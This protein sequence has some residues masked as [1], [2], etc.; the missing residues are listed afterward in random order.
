MATST[1]ILGIDGRPLV[2]ADG[3]A[4]KPRALTAE[5]EL[6]TISGVRQLFGETVAAGLL[7]GRLAA[8]LRRAQEGDMR[9]FLTLAEEMEERELQYASV[10]STRKRAIAGIE[11]VL[12][13]RQAKQKADEI[14][15]AIREDILDRP[16]FGELI[17]DLLDG[18]GKGY[19]AVEIIWETGARRW[20]PARFKRHDPRVF[21][22]DRETLSELRLRAD[23]NADG[24]PLDPLKWIIHCPRLKSG[25]PARSGLARLAAWA[26]MMKSFT[27][28]DWMTFLEVYGMPLRLG[29]YGPGASAEDK[30]VLLRAVRD[31]GSDAAAI[32]P[33][34]MEI[35]FVESKGFS[36]KPFEAMADYLDKQ[37]SKA[38]I[39]QTMTADAGSSKAQAEVHDL[40]R[41]DI[42]KADADQLAATLNRML[43]E[44]YVAV[45]FGPGAHGAWR[46]ALPVRVARDITALADALDKLVPLGLKVRQDEVREPLG[47]TDPEDDDEV[48]SPPAA[49]PATP[50]RATPAPPPA[51]AL[52]S[53][54]DRAGCPGCG[55]TRRALNT[56]AETDEIDKLVDELMADWRPDLAPIV[57]AVT[58][59]AAQAQSYAAFEE[60]LNGMAATLPVARLA[61]RIAVGTL[62]GR[63]AKRP[64]ASE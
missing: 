17:D 36:E 34:S 20:R 27:M 19:A 62:I 41:T 24:V 9:D 47:L 1:S 49:A 51:T 18:L 3:L 64:E 48:L 63:A 8:T 22:F 55:E 52:N 7:P 56:A 25:L 11:P 46:M 60:A 14:A 45:N 6:P 33:L 31:L 26:F 61:R 35:D 5:V 21:Q 38:I 54:F 15:D 53:L 32:I 57:E 2:G 10:L 42:K 13:G 50:E 4:L 16:E 44:P 12:K 37:I 30:A 40:V 43:I 23:A 28:K 59:A 29:K 39:G 58:E